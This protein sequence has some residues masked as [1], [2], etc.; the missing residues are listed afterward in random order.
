MGHGEIRFSIFG[1]A[2]KNNKWLLIQHLKTV[3]F[4]LEKK[5]VGLFMN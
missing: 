4:F 2:A 3:M 1:V 5:R